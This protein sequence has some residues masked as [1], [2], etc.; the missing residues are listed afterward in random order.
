MIILL[1]GPP[2]CGKDTAAGFIKKY[3]DLCREYKMS[4]PL[5]SALRTLLCIEDE[6][7]KEMLAYGAKDE[8]LLP[9]G[10]SIRQA[11]IRLSEDYLKPMLGDD[12]FGHIAVRHLIRMAS[13][14]NIVIPD[15][16]FTDE[17]VPILKEFT[18][19]K[20]RIIRLSRPGYFYT[21]DSR[22]DIDIDRLKMRPYT[23][24]INNKYDL[25]VFE[26]QVRVVL[27]K[28]DLIDDNTQ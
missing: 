2:G 22:S 18:A 24:M 5:K 7:W 12:I 19:K 11:L 10:V 17:V 15:T 27:R 23:E 3:L 6:R 13:A 4:M 8:P 16:G 26:A 1:N 9:K 14:A 25:E 28:W 20:I 21:N